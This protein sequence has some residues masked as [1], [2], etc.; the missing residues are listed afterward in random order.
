MQEHP[1][2]YK[3]LIQQ[4]EQEFLG[5]WQQVDLAK[6]FGKFVSFLFKVPL[7]NRLCKRNFTLVNILLS[8]YQKQNL[9]RPILKLVIELLSMP[10]Y[11]QAPEEWW[12]LMRY[13][14]SLLQHQQISYFL[15]DFAIEDQLII[16]AGNG[17]KDYVGYDVSYSLIGFSLWMFERGNVFA[18]IKLVEQATKADPTWA[19]PEYLL[20]WYGLFVQGVDSASHFVNAVHID[21]SFLQRIKKDRVCQKFPEIVRKVH[22]S[23]VILK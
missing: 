9:L 5:A 22:Q 12:R 14:T 13:T 18:A 3:D 11:K 20:G 7:L 8:Y 2:T 15:R 6:K 1:K 21:W 16:L 17:P 4:R 23:V 19:Y 10:H